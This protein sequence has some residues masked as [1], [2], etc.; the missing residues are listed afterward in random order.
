MIKTRKDKFK[1]YWKIVF[2]SQVFSIVIATLFYTFSIIPNNTS[3]LFKLIPVYI[4]ISIPIIIV[5]C[6][7]FEEMNSKSKVL[8][9][10][11]IT[12]KRHFLLTIS[13]SIIIIV[14]LVVKILNNNKLIENE[15]I[16]KYLTYEKNYWQEIVTQ[17]NGPLS[18]RKHLFPEFYENAGNQLIFPAQDGL[19]SVCF[20]KNF[21]FSTHRFNSWLSKSD[22]WSGPFVTIIETN[23]SKQFSITHWVQIFSGNSMKISIDEYDPPNINVRGNF[24]IFPSLSIYDPNTKSNSIFNLMTIKVAPDSLENIGLTLRN[25][26][27]EEVETGKIIIPFQW[28]QIDIYGKDA[29]RKLDV[30]EARL[31]ASRELNSVLAGLNLGMNGEKLSSN[32]ISPVLEKF[33]SVL[34]RF[35]GLLNDASTSEYDLQKF[36]NEYPVIISPSFLKVHSEV[37][38]GGEFITDFIIEE[39]SPNGSYCT[40]VEIE[41]PNYN[42]F[43]ENGDISV[44]LNHALKT[45]SNWRQWL[46]RNSIYAATSLGIKDIDS[47]S[48]VLIIIGRKKFLNK[49]NLKDLS[50]ISKDFNYKTQVLTYDDIFERAVHWYN[51]LKNLENQ[52]KVKNYN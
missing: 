25:I 29:I 52:F 41:S 37:K 38:W 39:N 48:P 20:S 7:V 43:L 14:I 23:L 5:L 33:I 21:S 28:R 18:T 46:R 3:V 11:F 35:A 10:F 51:N 45:V 4:I 1:R 26:K 31:K 19:V 44:S 30:N 16:N 49:N 13:I 24:P 42:L 15:L 17:L 47:D 6:L 27:V 8:K 36:L 40:L 9:T 32:P 34:N 50:A 22:K 2:S 12:Y